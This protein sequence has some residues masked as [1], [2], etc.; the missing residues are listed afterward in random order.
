MNK[1]KIQIYSGD[2]RDDLEARYEA[3]YKNWYSHKA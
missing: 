3:F 2:S 1:R